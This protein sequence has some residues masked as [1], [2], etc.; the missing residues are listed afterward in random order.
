MIPDGDEVSD[1]LAR[2]NQAFAQEREGLAQCNRRLSFLHQLTQ[3][4]AGAVEADAIGKALFAGLPSLIAADLIGLVGSDPEQVWIWSEPQ[5]GRKANALRGQLMSRLGG[6]ECRSVSSHRALRLLRSPHLSLV[7]MS[8]GSAQ[9]RGDRSVSVHEVTLAIGPHGAGILH[10]ERSRERPYSGQERQLLATVAA[11]LAVALGHADALRQMRELALRDPL[12]GVLN[13]PAL[14]GPLHRE[15]HAGLRYG[16]PACLLL[17]D[18]DYFQ[19]VNHVLGHAG[20]DGVLSRVTAL[21][22]ETVR[23]IDS[24][25]RYGGEE[26]AVVL[27]HKDLGQGQ[28]LAERIRA[29]IERRAFGLDDGSVR[30]TA[31]LGVASLLDSSIATVDHWIAAADSALY[32]AKSQGRNRVAIHAPCRLSPQQGAAVLA[33]A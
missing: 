4:L 22:Q 13:R 24:V 30:I 19:T 28:A 26:F 33:A 27:P 20:G 7:P 2:T 6:T 12:T 16:A 23:E 18:L 25:G 15:L 8:D 5:A 1:E 17:L 29:E 31:S 10:V 14:D 11:S 32:E 21:V 3:V 9:G